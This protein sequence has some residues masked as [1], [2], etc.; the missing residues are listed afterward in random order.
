MGEQII[1]SDFADWYS[2][3]ATLAFLK[4]TI[5]YQTAAYEIERRLIAGLCQAAARHSVY[6]GRQN[7]GEASFEIIPKEYWMDSHSIRPIDPFWATGTVKLA[8][9]RK[10]QPSYDAKWEV[11]YFDVRFEPSGVAAIVPAGLPPPVQ[12]PSLDKRPPASD[13]ELRRCAN[14]IVTAWGESV[15]DQRAHTLAKG[16]NPDNNVPRD[17]FLG[18]LREFTGEKSRGRPKTYRE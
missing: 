16:M 14:A 1:E 3:S 15:T 6:T 9:P 10:Y 18:I 8:L 13:A 12:T 2:P 7:E 5:S 17:R 11:E 4:P